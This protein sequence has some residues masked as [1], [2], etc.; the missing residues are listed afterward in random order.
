MAV[1][2]CFKKQ[3]DNFSLDIVFCSEKKRIAI[4]GASGSGKSVTL[5]ALSGIITPDNG[6]IEI[7]DKVLFD[8]KKRINIKTKD[9]N[10]GYMFQN[11]ALFPT[12]TV[13][14]NIESGF[15]GDKA[16]KDIVVD[17]IIKTYGLSGLENSLPK[18]LSG[19]QQQRVALAR[20]AVY[21]PLTIFLDEPFSALDAFLKDKLTQDLFSYLDSYDKTV[22]I[23]THDRDEAYRFS[24]DVVVLNEGRVETFGPT[25]EIFKNPKSVA[26]ARITGCKNISRAKIIDE[27]SFIALDW[28]ATVKTEKN[29]PKDFAFVGYRAHEFE[30]IWGEKEENCIEFKLHSKAFLQF[31][32]N[33]YIKPNDDSD[34][35]DGII[36]WFLQKDMWPVIDQKGE[37]DFLKIKQEEIMFLS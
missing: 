2:A 17:E 15:K 37:P 22:I 32:R 9:R 34:S 24:E 20:I 6:L 23:V 33:Y 27:H 13:R 29:L 16:Q 36:T 19:G 21:S 3:F 1:K 4:L 14:K 35:M 25:K 8:S 12:M 26:A 31:E 11:Y 7:D 30:P 10:I 18:D 28:N 5:K